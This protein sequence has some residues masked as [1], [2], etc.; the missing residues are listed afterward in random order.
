MAHVSLENSGNCPWPPD[1]V[2]QRT[3][4]MAL[5]ALSTFTITNLLPGESTQLFI[6]MRAPDEI[7]SYLTTWEMRQGEG[8]SFGSRIPIEVVVEDL[9]PL[10]P[11][12]TL[13]I[14]FETAV[15]ITISL[16]APQLVSWQAEPAKGSWSGIAQLQAT[17]GSG[18]HRYYLGEISRE[19]ELPDGTLR[20]EGRYCRGASLNLWVLSGGTILNWRGEIPYPAPE[21]CE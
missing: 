12:P 9:P 17:G 18:S 21:T 2:L 20:F 1:T 4:D 5:D 13:E 11:T 7:G 15:P 14:V 16:E 19:T 10:T 8:R 6:P 3:S